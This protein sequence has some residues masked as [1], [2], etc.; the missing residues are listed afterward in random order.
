MRKCYHGNILSFKKN[1][2]FALFF[3]QFV[4]L[5][6]I[7]PR[8][9]RFRVPTAWV[10]SDPTSEAK[11]AQLKIQT[12]EKDF[13]STIELKLNPSEVWQSFNSWLAELD[14]QSSNTHNLINFLCIIF[15]LTC[16]FCVFFFT[17]FEV[18]NHQDYQTESIFTQVNFFYTKSVLTETFLLNCR[19]LKKFAFS[20]LLFVWN[21]KSEIQIFLALNCTKLHAI[22]CSALSA[23]QPN[24]IDGAVK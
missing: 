13:W 2:C 3:F 6:K 17:W 21:R 15:L 11:I 24:F 18:S 8:Q 16:D 5:M 9:P 20:I 10:T 1:K 4:Y 7:W 14:W 12:I 19:V 23:K 22:C